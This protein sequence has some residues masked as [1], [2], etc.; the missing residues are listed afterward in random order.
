M[1][2]IFLVSEYILPTQNT[3]GYLFHKLHE[4]LKKQYGERLQLIVKEDPD[5][6]IE[7]AIL[8]TDVNLNKKQLVQRLIFELIVSFKFLLKLILN[9]KNNDVVFSGTNPSLLLPVIYFAQKIKK[10]KWILLIHDV[11]PENLIAA[12]ILKKNNIFYRL[13]KYFFDKFYSSAD[14]RIVIGKDMKTLVDN[15]VRTND[16]IIIQNWIDHHDIDVHPKI[17]NPII[18][19]L[20]WQNDQPI[21]QFFG[22]IGRVQGIHNILEA[23]KL[24]EKN[25]RPKI[26]F[27]GGGAYENELSAELER[28]K[29]PN[30]QYIGSIDQSQKSQGLNAGDIAIV[31]LADG[32]LGLGVPSKAYFSMAA[33]K[34]ILAIME[35]DSEV[36]RMI[37]KY[38]IGWVVAPGNPKKLAEAFIEIMQK[39][40]SAKNTSPR[41]ILV[42]NYSEEIAM[43]KLINVIQ[44][45]FKCILKLDY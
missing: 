11:F 28:I 3:T 32:M 18:R 16:S 38:E 26:L 13:L 21:F 17:E 40:K 45:I 34:P 5:H 31:T 23:F 29:D 7:N 25:L 43:N 4:N 9:V 12:K 35:E 20:G 15:K 33:D 39:Y 8:I 6:L 1:K 27:I 2:K 19:Q 41:N 30:I 42:E 44:K 37:Q 24:I 10:F 14:I 36:A 22:N